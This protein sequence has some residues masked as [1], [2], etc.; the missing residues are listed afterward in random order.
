MTGPRQP[1]SCLARFQRRPID[2]E[3]EKRDG[4]RRHGILVISAE[5][6]RLAWPE[7]E[8]VE[9]LGAKLYGRRSEARDG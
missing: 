4:W 6:H 1:R 7:R 2:V 9:Q 5:D 3:A 8:L